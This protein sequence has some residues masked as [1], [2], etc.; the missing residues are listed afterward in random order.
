VDSDDKTAHISNISHIGVAHDNKCH[1]HPTSNHKWGE[2]SH[3]PANK[4]FQWAYLFPIATTTAADKDNK[5]LSASDDQ[6]EL[7]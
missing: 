4:P 2:W 7:L 6:A 3:N 5:A 1:I